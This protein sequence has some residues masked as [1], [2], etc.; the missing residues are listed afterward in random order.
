MWWRWDL[1]EQFGVWKSVL[2][3]ACLLW[4]SWWGCSTKGKT[5]EALPLQLWHWEDWSHRAAGAPTC[6]RLLAACCVPL[7]MYGVCL[8]AKGCG[9]YLKQSFHQEMVMCQRARLNNKGK[10]CL[11][12][13]GDFGC[14]GFEIS[15]L[16]DLEQTSFHCS[17][18]PK[19][20]CFTFLKLHFHKDHCD[21]K[22][23]PCSQDTLQQVIS[24]S[25]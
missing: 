10:S 13:T 21:V 7:L 24:F 11:E 20:R 5:G 2:G 4:I 14:F 3:H 25:Y 16:R 1:T 6:S 18:L 15:G 19:I 8:K 22:I 12:A 9:L 23:W 17:A